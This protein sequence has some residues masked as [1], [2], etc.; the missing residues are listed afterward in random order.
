MFQIEWANRKLFAGDTK[1]KSQPSRISRSGIRNVLLTRWEEHCVECAVPDCYK[2]CSLY[3]KR[4]DGAC[5]RFVY[6]IVP[7]PGFR[8]HYGFGADI[9]FRKWGKIE[10]DL[11]KSFPIPLIPHF[12]LRLYHQLPGFIKVA[13]RKWADRIYDRRGAEPDE[14]IIECY[15][16]NEEKFTMIIEYFIENNSI[17][18][19]KF[20]QTI[21]LSRG[22]NFFKIPYEMIH[23]GK[24]EGY[25]YL[26]PENNH[27]E[28]RLI[29]TW[30]DFVK[31]KVKPDR[32][33]GASLG[34][35]GKMIKCVAWDLDNTLW[36]GILTEQSEVRPVEEALKL[37]KQLDEKG[38]IQ[39]IISKNNF[40][41]AWSQLEK[42]GVAE[43]FLY[44]AI[45]WGQ[46]S[47]NLLKIA[48]KMNIDPDSIAVIDDSA[49]E[50]EEIR[51]NLPGVK[52]YSEKEIGRI[53]EYEEFN[54][55][56]SEFSRKRRMNYLAE[57]ER[58]Q[59]RDA[60]S[61]SYE[62]FLV[63]CR[64]VLDVFVPDT[65]ADIRRCLELIQR[66]NQLNL[67]SRRYSEQEFEKLL[68][69]KT[70][71]CL[72]LKCKD[73]FADYGIIGFSSINL[74]SG[75]PV[76]ED[77]VLSCR[78]AQ[79]RIEHTFLGGLSDYY[80]KKGCENLYARLIPT[81]KNTPLRL[82]FDD[83]PFVKVPKNND[84]VLLQ[85]DLTQ[86]INGRQVI[87]LQFT[88]PEEKICRN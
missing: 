8:G 34:N 51:H 56:V 54:I 50:R 1:I 36:A 5:A 2:I 80:R 38:I 76:L 57:I 71:Q 61:D 62:D 28:K 75:D 32:D 19:T 23:M 43:Y 58:N 6:G 72:A 22:Y 18:K 26:Y 14:F 67:S 85:L 52:V 41:Q 65:E 59:F 11:N 60:F 17:R 35:P 42:I 12:W 13:I 3:Q 68:S 70:V 64:M 20:R 47:E 77:F 31:Y 81:K 39:T 48:E 25:L 10:A 24:P 63:S 9:T 33:H 66:S 86:K 21:T 37:I 16:D 15:S 82:V 27:P 29:F 55:P 4:K 83:L 7:N 44:P 74:S 53:M 79:K 78:V 73:R 87:E 45:N 69:D 40:E 84:T 30:L 46:K 49:F 88:E